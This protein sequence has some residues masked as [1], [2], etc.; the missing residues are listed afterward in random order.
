[1]EFTDGQTEDERYAESMEWLG[2]PELPPL[3]GTEK[4]IAYA[5]AIR[6]AWITLRYMSKQ[7]VLNFLKETEATFFIRGAVFSDCIKYLRA[8]NKE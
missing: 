3:T 8:K 2:N 6:H 1:M 7:T 5:E 4:Q